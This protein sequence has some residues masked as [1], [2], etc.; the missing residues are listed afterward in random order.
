MPAAWT[1]LSSIALLRLGVAMLFAAAL[2]VA[3]AQ[4]S[5]QG[6]VVDPPARVGGISLLAGPVSL[7][8]LSSGSRE[9]ALLNWPITAGWRLETGPNGRAEVRIGSTALQLDDE[10]TVDFVR[11]D[12]QFMQLAVLRG[13]VSLRLRS[14]E[15]LTELELLTQRERIVFDDLGRYRIDVDRS[16]G[17]TAVTSFGGRAR[18]VSGNSSF[19]VA[20]DQRGEVTAPPRSRIGLSPAQPDRFD[21]WV[22]ER[23][24]RDDS[25]NSTAYVSRETT[26]VEQLDQYGDWRVVEDHGAVWFPRATIATWAPYRFGRWVWLHPW[27]WTWVDEAPWGFAP[28]HYGRWIVI[29]SSW[30]WVPGRVVA[31]P[32]FAPA[33]VA[34]YGVPVAGRGPVGWFPLGPREPYVPAHRHSPRYLRVVNVQNVPQVDRLTIVQTPKYVNR[35]PDRS[36]W[37]ADDRFGR[38]EPVS[39]GQRPPPSE[40]QQYIARPQPPANVPNTKRRQGNEIVTPATPSPMPPRPADTGTRPQSPA[41]QDSA[42]PRE[43][44]QPRA[45]EAPS[46]VEA[47]RGMAPANGQQHDPRY[48]PPVDPRAAPGR[49]YRPE[50]SERRA[51]PRPQPVSP[52]PTPQSPSQPAQPVPQPRVDQVP[53]GDGLPRQP[54]Q[55]GRQMPA[56]TFRPDDVGS[57]DNRRYSPRGPEVPQAPRPQQ[58]Q[59][60]PTRPAPPVIAPAQVAPAQVAPVQVSPARVAPPQL[61]PAAPA[62]AAPPTAPTQPAPL[63]PPQPPRDDSGGGPRQ[64]RPPYEA[65]R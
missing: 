44:G 39:R 52:A 46:A 4:G 32:V 43:P 50:D 13:S 40:W 25:L 9:E 34:W 31:R 30:G 55:P 20:A 35:H 22:A 18:I 2:T 36:T 3:Q 27:G 56:P 15:T 49:P 5:E 8:D 54:R 53:A 45:V 24:A 64:G 17:I 33:L 42:L 10:T 38:P 51:A 6:E 16:P 14:R 21:T 7:L 47:P 19:V 29:G 1:E 48:Q 62:Q 65:S 58:P 23:D 26:G 11:L 59:I 61:A 41:A 63:R 37:V 60:A 57:Q 12:D 28:L